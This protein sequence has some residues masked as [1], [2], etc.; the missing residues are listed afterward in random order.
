MHVVE[1]EYLKQ[2]TFAAIAAHVNLFTSGTNS[3]LQRLQTNPL[4]AV[5]TWTVAAKYVLQLEILPTQAVL[6]VFGK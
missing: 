2:L 5:V 4:G 3:S 1:S 6:A